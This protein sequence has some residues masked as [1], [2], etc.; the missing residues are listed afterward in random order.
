M[1]LVVAGL[2]K[3]RR[4]LFAHFRRLNLAYLDGAE[5]APE[6]QQMIGYALYQFRRVGGAWQTAGALREALV[7]PGI[8]PLLPVSSHFDALAL[9][10]ETPFL[11]PLAAFG[12][13][14]ART[15]PRDPG[16][17]GAGAESLFDRVVA[18]R[19]SRED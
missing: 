3:R 5:P 9:M 19:V 7:L 15:P 13:V 8:C 2:V 6:F 18:F 11:R 10:L 14:E 12:L 1:L 17:P 4:G 16:E